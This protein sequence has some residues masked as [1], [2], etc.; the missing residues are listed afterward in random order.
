MSSYSLKS[1]EKMANYKALGILLSEGA[2][3]AVVKVL[4]SQK[5]GLDDVKLQLK[6]FC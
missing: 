2:D 6:R 3:Y 4:K 1:L 5:E